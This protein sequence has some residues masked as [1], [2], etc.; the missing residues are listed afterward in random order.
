[1]R[2]LTGAIGGLLVLGCAVAAAEPDVLLADEERR[3]AQVGADARALDRTLHDLLVYR[4]SDGREEGK[5]ELIASLTGGTVDY[6]AIRVDEINT[7]DCPGAGQCVRARQTLEVV[8]EDRNFAVP[9]CYVAR[10]SLSSA[11][12]Q[13]IA[14]ESALLDEQGRCPLP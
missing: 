14:Y 10:Y 6:R 2:P 9:S 11:R 1:M 3:A 4:H 7:V 13:L 12:F 5:S 8:F